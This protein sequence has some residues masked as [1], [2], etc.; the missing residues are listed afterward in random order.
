MAHFWSNFATETLG[1]CVG[2]I[3][4]MRHDYPWKPK[5]F[6]PFSLDDAENRLTSSKLQ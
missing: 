4:T 2:A 1:S 6:L 5:E 3:E